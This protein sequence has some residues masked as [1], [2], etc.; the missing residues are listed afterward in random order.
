MKIVG[1]IFSHEPRLE[2]LTPLEMIQAGKYQIE[3][4]HRFVTLS[5]T[6]PGPVPVRKKT[7]KQLEK[8]KEEGYVPPPVTNTGEGDI[9]PYQVSMQFTRI[10]RRGIVSS[11]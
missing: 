5:C 10:I 3:H 1:W 9:Q 6:I 8:E 4:G 11:E 2:E 7:E